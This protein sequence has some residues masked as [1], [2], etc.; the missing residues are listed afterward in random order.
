MC[1]AIIESLLLAEGYMAFMQELTEVAGILE[2]VS[3]VITLPS[4]GLEQYDKNAERMFNQL[5]K[6]SGR[7]EKVYS[8]VQENEIAQDA[9]NG[10]YNKA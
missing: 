9:P 2:K 5:Q 6:V 4:S 8:P 10:I 3:V 7:V 1:H